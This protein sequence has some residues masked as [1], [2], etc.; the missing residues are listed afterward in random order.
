MKQYPIF[1]NSDCIHA[2]VL[3]AGEVGIRKIETLMQ[4]GAKSL[5]VYDPFVSEQDFFAKISS[6]KNA[7]CKN[8]FIN[9]SNS[10]D[11][12]LGY[13]QEEFDIKNFPSYIL[14]LLLQMMQ[15]KILSM[16]KSVRSIR[17]FVMS[18]QIQVRVC[19]PCQP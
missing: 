3:G 18:S 4:Q 15:K 5:D 13:Y 9:M 17:Y 2:L 10:L 6:Y 1:I 7:F 19:S 16:S 14:S 8:A 11:Y 12:A